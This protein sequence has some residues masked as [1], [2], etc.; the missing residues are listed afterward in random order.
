MNTAKGP[1]GQVAAV[2]GDQGGFVDTYSRND[3][4]SPDG[5]ATTRVA[6]LLNDRSY[7]APSTLD[8]GGTTYELSGCGMQ[9][10]TRWTPARL[11]G[12]NLR[13]LRPKRTRQTESECG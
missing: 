7:S 9:L 4:S 2:E 6:S 5:G 8:D 10:G 3:R 13:V 12:E 1:C 11:G